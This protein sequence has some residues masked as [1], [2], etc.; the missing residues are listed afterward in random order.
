[1]KASSISQEAL[2]G[3][4]ERNFLPRLIDEVQKQDILVQLNAIEMLTE[5][6]LTPHGLHYL[7][8]RNVLKDLEKILNTPDGDPLR[9]FLVPGNSV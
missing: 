3:F 8:D 4:V 7:E 6:A 5:L 2:D 9:S 1:M